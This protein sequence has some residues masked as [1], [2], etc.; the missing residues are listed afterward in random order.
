MAEL[1]KLKL[2][3]FDIKGK[4]EPIRLALR[5]LGI[6]FEDYRFKDGEFMELKTSGKLMFG[7]VRVNSLRSIE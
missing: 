6:P 7:Q 5:Y 2:M 3:Y 4:G 1:P